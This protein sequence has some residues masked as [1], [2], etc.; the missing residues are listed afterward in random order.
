[1]FTIKGRVIGGKIVLDRCDRALPEHSDLIISFPDR[2]FNQIRYQRHEPRPGSD[3]RTRLHPRFNIDGTINIVQAAPQYDIPTRLPLLD[4]SRSGISFLATRKYPCE[5]RVR[6]GI[7]APDDP[8][9]IW[10]EVDM[11]VRGVSPLLGGYKVGCMFESSL[12]QQLWYHLHRY[13]R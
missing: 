13:L 6:A 5:S 8:K 2:G 1:M 9:D 10:L 4:I 11:E 7:T 12:D 3:A